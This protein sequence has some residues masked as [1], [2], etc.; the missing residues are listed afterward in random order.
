L[1]GIPGGNRLL[2]LSNRSGT[3][4][5]W[6]TLPGTDEPPRPVATEGL[7][8]EDMRVSP[9]G[10]VVAVRARGKGIF[11]VPLRGGEAPRQLTTD[12]SDAGAAFS[13]DGK[14]IFFSR[15]LPDGLRQGWQVRLDGSPPSPLLPPHTVSPMESPTEPRLF[16]FAS[17]PAGR[18]PMVRD[19]RTGRDAPL[20]KDMPRGSYS[21]PCFTWDGRRI[22]MKRGDKELLE[23]DVSSGALVRTVASGEDEMDQPVC[24]KD[25]VVV[26]R[27]EHIGDMWMADLGGDE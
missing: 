22:V 20:S 16:Y 1:A 6:D 2:V 10:R 25:G 14:T 5:I 27:H 13:R 21:E 9:D 4:S 18:I 17:S 24:V 19:L 3:D 23:V 7:S 15:L 11:V 26:V 12:A 8:P